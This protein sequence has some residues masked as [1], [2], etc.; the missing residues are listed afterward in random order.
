[1]AAIFRATIP[2]MYTTQF[3]R[4]IARANPARYKPEQRIRSKEN[5]ATEAAALW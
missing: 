1:L 2:P 3:R 5:A 4:N